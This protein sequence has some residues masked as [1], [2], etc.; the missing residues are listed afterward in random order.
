MKCKAVS[1]VLVFYLDKELSK[2]ETKEIEAHLQT[3][4]A[5][6]TEYDRLAESAAKL[7]QL[8][9]F[10]PSPDFE[11]TFWN[12]V[13]RRKTVQEKQGLGP[14]WLPAPFPV[15]VA[16]LLALAIGAGSSAIL[17]ARQQS[18]L[19]EDQRLSS[20]LGLSDLSASSDSMLEKA[21]FQLDQKN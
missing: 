2:E 7:G 19:L 17:T 20:G 12:K 4:K 13:A 14:W 5:C 8:P 6:Q 9:V 11:R 21:Y 15:M 10:T 1:S 3:C 18:K 16:I